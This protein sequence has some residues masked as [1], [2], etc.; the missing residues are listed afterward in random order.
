MGFKRWTPRREYTRQEQALLK[1]LNR[2]RKLF[3]FLR[4]HRHELFDDEFQAELESMYRGTG[5]GKDPV[6][7][8]LMAMAVLLQGYLGMSDAEAVELTVVDLRWQMVLDRLGSDKPAFSQGAL[9]AFRDRLIRTDM[10]RRLLE[11]TVELARKTK[12]FDPKK[13]PTSLRTAMDSAPLQ[14]AGRVEDTINLIAHAARKVVTCAAV[15]LD[16]KPDEVCQ[17]AGI[18]L[19]LESSV[20]KGLDREWGIPA[21]KA[22]AINELMSQVFALEGWV[23]AHLPEESLKPPL[24]EDLDTLQQVVDQDLEPDPDDDGGVKIRRGVAEDRRVSIEDPEMRHGRKTK[25]KRF[26]GYKRHLATDLDA[27]LVLACAVTP[28]NRPEEEAAADLKADIERQGN[29]ID[30]LFIDRGYINS[31]VVSEILAA[32]GKVVCR[33][34]LARNGDLFSKEDFSINMRDRT[35]TCPAGVSE[36]FRLDSVVQFP[37]ELCTGCTVRSKCTTA[38]EGRGRTVQIGENEQLQ[39]RLRKQSKTKR[40]RQRLRERV[41][42]EHHLAHAVRRQGRRARYV[43][44]RKNVYDL[45]RTAAIQNL[46]TIHRKAG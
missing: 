44:V 10:D 6:S 30:E 7:P 28:A 8:A 21:K 9:Q 41:P 13:L 45:R 18:P 29:D 12:G 15:L 3:R 26:N 42:V 22:D 32:G 16:W 36:K 33:P 38:A 14:G 1:R 20:K 46:E 23:A 35:I 17:D 27:E 37:P 11:Q 5:A 31:P 19:L 2:T 39:Q 34:W 25:S 43:G 40:G 4:E 24:K